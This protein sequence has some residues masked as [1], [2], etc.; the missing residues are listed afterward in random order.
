MQWEGRE[1]EMEEES[2]MI[3]Q[4]VLKKVMR[5]ASPANFGSEVSSVKKMEIFFGHIDCLPKPT[6]LSRNCVWCV[7][8]CTIKVPFLE[9]Q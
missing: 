5:R 4:V 2:E 6:S 9:I 1:K 3:L 7:H 8:V